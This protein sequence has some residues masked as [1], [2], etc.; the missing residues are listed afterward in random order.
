MIDQPPLLYKFYGISINIQGIASTN[1]FREMLQLISPDSNNN[2]VGHF[3]L[4]ILEQF[5]NLY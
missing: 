4:L 1:T 2:T 3:W 5:I